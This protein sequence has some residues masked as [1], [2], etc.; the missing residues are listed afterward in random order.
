[1][2]REETKKAA[3]TMLAHAEGKEIEILVYDYNGRK[4]WGDCKN[5]DWNWDS[6]DYRIKP[7]QT[8]N[9]EELTEQESNFINSF[10]W[11]KPNHGYLTP[12]TGLNAIHVSKLYTSDNPHFLRKNLF[13]NP[14]TNK[15]IEWTEKFRDEL[16]KHYEVPANP[17]PTKKKFYSC[18]RGRIEK[19]RRLCHLGKKKR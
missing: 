14:L 17:K 9:E 7:E 15:W 5:P 1:M 13:L 12:L 2:T 16:K 8:S 4:E 6:H 18:D 3:E 11:Y 19:D 10:I